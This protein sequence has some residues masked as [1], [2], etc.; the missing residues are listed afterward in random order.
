MGQ[1]LIVIGMF[2]LRLGVPLAVTLGIGYL[3]RRLDARWEAEAIAERTHQAA[4]AELEA[5]KPER[6]CWE[7]KGCPEEK[8]AGCPACAFWD[9]PCWVA[10]LRATGRLPRECYDCALFTLSPV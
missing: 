8:K 2:I 1:V 9:I 3:L 5:L 4:P 6:P 10:R 7:I